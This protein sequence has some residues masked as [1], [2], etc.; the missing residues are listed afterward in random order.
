MVTLFHRGDAFEDA[1]FT[2]AFASDV[3]RVPDFGL[4]FFFT[5]GGA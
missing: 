3:G 4:E 2:A 1:A 5:R